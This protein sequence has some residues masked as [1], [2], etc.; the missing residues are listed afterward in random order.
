MFFPA[1]VLAQPQIQEIEVNQAIGKQKNDHLYFVAGK[2]TVVRAHLTEEVDINKFIGKV[3]AEVKNET[4]NKS[5]TLKHA[6][7]ENSTDIVEFY[8]SPSMADCDNWAEGTYKFTVT[9]G[10][11]VKSTDGTVYEFKKRVSLKVLAVPVKAR[12][13]EDVISYDKDNYKSELKELIQKTYP[14]QDDGIVWTLHPGLDASQKKYNQYKDS[15]HENLANLLAQL[16]GKNC[17]KFGEPS[18]KKDCFDLIVGF[19]S[20]LPKTDDN[21]EME[22]YTYQLPASIVRGTAEDAA[23]TVAHEPAHGWDI[24]DTYN[25]TG[26]LPASFNCKLNPAPEGYKGVDIL[27]R[28]PVT[29]EKSTTKPYTHTY[30]E[31]GVTYESEIGALIPNEAKAF[32]VKARKSL[33]E[34][35]DFMSSGGKKDMFW[36]TPD[37]F[38]HLFGK[39]KPKVAAKTALAPQLQ[40]IQGQPQRL[41]TYQGTIAATNNTVTLRPWDSFYED[42]DIADTVGDYTIQALRHD[43]Q[44]LASQAMKVDFYINTNP[45]RHIENAPFRGAMRFPE[46]TAK[47]Q[48]VRSADNA[49]LSEARV[50]ANL[51]QVSDIQ[52]VP[53]GKGFQRQI[54]WRGQ[55]S[56]GGPLYYEVAYNADPGN[57]DSRWIVLASDL[58]KQEWIGDFSELPGGN[59][60]RIRVS[61]TDGILTSSAEKK[62]AKVSKQAPQVFIDEEV[63]L[64]GHEFDDQTWLVGDAV[65]LND[66]EIPDDRLEWVSDISGS[67]GTGSPLFVESLTPGEHTI[68][69]LA[70]NRAGLTGS[71]EVKLVVNQCSFDVL[72]DSVSFT[73]H[74]GKVKVG[75]NVDG[76]FSRRLRCALTD[77]DLSL[78]S[79][80]SAE[81]LRVKV[82]S[83]DRNT[84]IIS[85]DPNHDKSSRTG[86]IWV[87]SNEITVTQLGKS[88]H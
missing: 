85:A 51:P 67:L 25:T 12:F 58:T 69:L 6:V 52:V 47:F 78:D 34:K 18:D 33:G 50:S 48:I 32:D 37:V 45:S 77:D 40:D 49:V 7:G 87:L 61:V 59:K 41:I 10:D 84:V 20:K 57:I 63:G 75:V 46:G 17:P 88:V 44:V 80:D 11:S 56:D 27:T 4:T 65:D 5:F 26:S 15:G 38:D 73:H 72:S 54:S 28:K 14:V 42:A 82:N 53:K 3:S 16:N 29:C 43:G 23:G 13:G 22:G 35:A 71:A 9:V 66:G 81:W 68:S 79:D 1:L 21:A 86:V 36:I 30:T 31:K 55:D 2:S 24:G 39:F 8:C 64:H 62:I 70:T 74:G 83:R 76:A 60:P 19:I